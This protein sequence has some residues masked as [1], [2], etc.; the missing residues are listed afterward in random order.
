M[1]SLSVTGSA[2]TLV[3]APPKIGA[4]LVFLQ[5]FLP[6]GGSDWIA[7]GEVPEPTSILLLG[8]GLVG[9]AAGL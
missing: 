9:I 4:G 1:V 2:S 5:Q 6:N 7:D 8:S 3:F